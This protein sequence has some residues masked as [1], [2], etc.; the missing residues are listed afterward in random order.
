MTRPLTR[1]SVLW[2]S[3]CWLAAAAEAQDGTISGSVTDDLKAVLQAV[4]IT[5]TSTD[6]NRRFVAH[7]GERGDFRLMPIPPGV[8]E[9]HAAR[10]GFA[11]V[12]FREVV[13]LTG[14][15]V[16]LSLV[17]PI[18]PV[19]SSVSVAAN[20]PLVN[21]R[22][23]EVAGNVDRRQMELLPI[24]G[25]NW[26]ELTKFVKGMTAND[27]GRN[28]PGVRA[29]LFQLNLDG[30]EI[31][32]GL[33]TTG[34]GQPG[35]SRDAIAEFQ[36]VTNLF[37]VTMGRSAGIQVQ[38]I[39][40]SGT[41]SLAGSAYGYFRDDALNAPDAFLGRVLP[42]S[43][44]Q[45][46]GTLGGPIVK[47]RLHYFAAQEFE[48]EPSTTVVAPS[49]LGGQRMSFPTTVTMNSTLLRVDGQLT[50]RDHVMVRANYYGREQPRD[51]NNH[52]SRGAAR[53]IWSPFFNATWTRVISSTVVQELKTGF[54][55]YR[56]VR[57]PMEGAALTPEYRFPGLTLG[58]LWNYPQ[59][60]RHR[61]APLRYDLFWQRGTHELK[62]G[63]EWLIGLDHAWWPARERGQYFFAALPAD[64]ARRFPLD[65]WD[66]PSRWD[67]SGLDPITL[68]YDVSYARDWN[69]HV[70]R[71]TYAAWFGDTWRVGERVTLNYG[72]RYDL[73]W[74]DT[75]PP[76]ID[77]TD[78]IV[79]NGKTVENVGLRND[80]RDINN[81]APRVGVV[82]QPHGRKLVVRAG[83]GLF[84][85]NTSSNQAIDHQ[86]FSGQRLILASYA[87]DGRPGFIQDPTRGVTAEDVLGGNAPATPQA[88]SAIAHDFVF[89]LGWQTAVGVQRQFGQAT[90][91]E[92][93]LTYTTGHHED[94]QRDPNLFYDPATGFNLNPSR[95]GRPNPSFGPI[96][97]KESKGYSDL[98][99]L[100]VALN[101][102]YRSSFQGGIA[103]TTMF[104]KRDTGQGEAGY[105]AQQTNPFDIALDWARSSDF[106]RHTL[107]A[108]GFWTLPWRLDVAASFAYGSGTYTTPSSGADPLGTGSTRVRRDGTVVE[109]N[110]F[111]ADPFQAL[112]LRLSHRIPL[113]G[114][115]NVELV[116][117]VF[118]AYN[119]ARYSYN[120][121]ET[122]SLFGQPQSAASDPRTIQLAVRVAF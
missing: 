76:F 34:F 1:L 118:N 122:S 28:S 53:T 33:S 114:R 52:P 51:L 64:A 12:I 57:E 50:D 61:R 120:L 37:D 86:H 89:P 20:A 85:G 17:L 22:T 48:R 25:R 93:D 115:A 27:I 58:P 14:Q 100:A 90:N 6:T 94:S 67:F 107:R 96:L 80:I 43:N 66:D 72:L 71:P 30:Q 8:Y 97:L 84:Y 103:Y 23:T 98:L 45:I 16:N 99:E 110:S 29:A 42:Y 92:A 77:E 60:V 87:N 35:I 59:D 26:L 78:W 65:S 111:H 81:L 39:T 49:A 101:R 3:M 54:Y 24:K 91:F 41:N 18:A 15:H 55:F 106:Q 63:G 13:V 95:A 40:R 44:Q 36:V 5:A 73:A 31:T 68:R 102:R 112:D 2:L 46:G 79:D 7:T 82:W 19:E 69:F 117:E 10:S 83:T 121:L 62:V 104:F 4:T 116:G 74:G 75:A 113:R 9:L 11:S 47:D 119:D 38:A 56:S 70:P 32:Q 88:P 105:G 109:R 108:H 21:T